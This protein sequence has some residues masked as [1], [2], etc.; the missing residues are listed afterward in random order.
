M[1]SSSWL[2]QYPGAKVVNPQPPLTDQLGA[3]GPRTRTAA[4]IIRPV[5][6]IN[7]TLHGNEPANVLDQARLRILR[8]V[9]AR[10]GRPLPKEAWT[11]SSFQLEEIGA[12]FASAVSL[13]TPRY[14]A[15]RLDDADK[16]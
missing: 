12:Q 11:G 15:A 10:S 4:P 7:L 14:W 6:Q 5:S 1:R 8:W 9:S 3:L 13:D 16:D 2:G